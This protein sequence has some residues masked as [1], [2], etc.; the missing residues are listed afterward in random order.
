MLGNPTRDVATHHSSKG[1][2]FP[3][4]MLRALRR[5]QGGCHEYRALEARRKERIVSHQRTLP[6][7]HC[8]GGEGWM[9]LWPCLSQ[10]L[11]FWKFTHS[12]H[13][14]PGTIRGNSLNLFCLPVFHLQEGD[15]T[16]LLQSL[17]FLLLRRSM[18]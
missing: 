5:C 14:L 13:R 8:R 7:P 10:G 1:K 3:L 9:I 12:A 17:C 11:K 6:S 18:R 2:T 16:S 4:E 15:N